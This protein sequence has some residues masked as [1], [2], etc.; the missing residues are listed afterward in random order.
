MTSGLGNAALLAVLAIVPL[1][2]LML[3]SFVKIS[4]VLSLLRNA[5]GAPDA[6][7]G[8][9]VIGLSLLLTF[10]VMAP[11]AIDMV[12]AAA[13]IP[14]TPA[15]ERDKFRT[16]IERGQTPGTTEVYVSHRGMFEVCCTETCS[17]GSFPHPA[18]AASPRPARTAHCSPAWP[19]CYPGSSPPPG[20]GCRSCSRT[21][22][23]ARRASA[24]VAASSAKLAT[25]STC[26][27]A[28]ASMSEGCSRR[29]C[30]GQPKG[31]LHVRRTSFDKLS[32][33]VRMRGRSDRSCNMR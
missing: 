31:D 25:R 21:P 20:P 30:G 18:S 27:P 15:P 24:T 26:L 12:H 4:V 11:V 19:R 13:V 2:V 14:T 22:A 28:A 16:R 6:P 3:T 7:S 32:P 8:L 23:P 33:H 10:F 17:A 5:L 9:V 29:G 1:V